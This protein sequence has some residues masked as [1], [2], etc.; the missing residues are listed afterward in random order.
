MAD[1]E[2][3]INISEEAY[4]ARKHW[5]INPKRMV[6]E[7]D[8]AIANGTPLPK[9]HGKLK[10]VSKIYSHINILNRGKDKGKFTGVL[11]IINM[12]ETII[13]ADKESENADSN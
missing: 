5:V 1:V 9:G 4:K 11:A 13:E 12:A 7:V 2:L 6:N 10:D 8:K 3:V